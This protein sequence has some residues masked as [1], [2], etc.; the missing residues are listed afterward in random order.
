V[1]DTGIGIAKEDLPKL[2]QDFGQATAAPLDGQGA[3]SRVAHCGD[4]PR[5]VKAW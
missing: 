3:H 4:T 5:P 2:F 1:H